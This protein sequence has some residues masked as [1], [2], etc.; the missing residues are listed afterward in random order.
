MRPKC[1][2]RGWNDPPMFSFSSLQSGS[3]RK[4]QMNKRV[5]HVISNPNQSLNLATQKRDTSPLPPPGI[6]NPGPSH[7]GVPPTTFNIKEETKPPITSTGTR[8]NDINNT[9][10]EHCENEGMGTS[11]ESEGRTFDQ[12]LTSLTE[13]TEKHCETMQVSRHERTG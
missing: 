2:E 4:T 9:C 10:V 1:T 6:P 5:N 7:P 12:V 8:E 13:L 11:E 3:G